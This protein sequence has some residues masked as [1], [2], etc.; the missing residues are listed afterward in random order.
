MMSQARSRRY[1]VLACNGVEEVHWMTRAVS[2]S[3]K[4][5]VASRAIRR[6]DA[7]AVRTSRMRGAEAGTTVP[8]L[9]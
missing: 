2:P 3:C 7:D 5:P 9:K 1:S 6:T 8:M 4:W